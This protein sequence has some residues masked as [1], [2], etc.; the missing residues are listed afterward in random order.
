MKSWAGNSNDELATVIAN[1]FYSQEK[2]E[3]AKDELTNLLKKDF[4]VRRN[5]KKKLKDLEDVLDLYEE[6]AKSK[7]KIKFVSDSYKQ[8]PPVGIEFIAPMLINL[9]GEVTK[10]N[11]IL[12]KILDIKSEVLNTAD[13]V[14]QM[15]I[16]VKTL[17]DNFNKAVGGL[18]AATQD[19]I[20]NN[21]DLQMLDDVTSFRLSI[22]LNSHVS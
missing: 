7:K 20:V 18:Q 13:T 12:P 21:T 4:L 14:R 16:D 9:T 2:I 5:P 22:R 11:E 1:A 15:G 19:V 17:N 6:C 3:V 8:L 10:I